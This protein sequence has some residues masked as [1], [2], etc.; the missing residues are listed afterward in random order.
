MPAASSDGIPMSDKANW[1]GVDWRISLLV[2]C[3]TLVIVG[4]TA[5][6]YLDPFI[7]IIL[8]GTAVVWLVVQ[9]WPSQQH[10]SPPHPPLE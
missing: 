10:K 3:A 1:K 5:G 9:N 2:I 7:G 4:I 8:T 6:H